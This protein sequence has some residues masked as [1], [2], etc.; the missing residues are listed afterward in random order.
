MRTVRRC[1][2]ACNDRRN[3]GLGNR[4]KWLGESG[5]G[6]Q[7]PP[8]EGCDVHVFVHLG[9]GFGAKAWRERYERGLIPGLNEPVP[10]GYHRAG[11]EGL[12]IE[13]SQDTNEGRLSAL[14]RRAVCR[15]FGFDLIHAWRNRM[16]LMTADVVWTHTEREHL[17]ALFLLQSVSPRKRPRIIAQC[18]WMFDE[19]PRLS[20]ARR[21]LYSW[22][23]SQAD[24]VTTLSPENLDVARRVLPRS[25]TELVRFGITSDSLKPARRAVCHRPVRVAALGNDMHRDW[26]TLLRAFGGIP[27]FELRIASSKVAPRL[28][29]GARNVRVEPARSREQ[30]ER[31]YEWADMVVVPLNPNL[32]A[33]G[34]SVI[35]EAT[36]SGKPLIVSDTGGLRAYFSSEEVNYV[37]VG[38]AVAMRETAWEMSQDDERRFSL[39]TLAQR[40]IVEAGLTSET[41]ALRHRRLSQELLGGVRLQNPPSFGLQ[42]SG[43]KAD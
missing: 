36:S 5:A 31:L 32:H 10:Y 25:R 43:L 40:R 26:T 21:R 4:E 12:V 20:W 37:A 6:Y 35:L 16:G 42:P 24:I 17:A 18:I 39:V 7:G 27:T 14:C 28:T 3:A 38:D 11:G 22:L 29:Q 1:A 19:W 30:V 33:S 2:K 23:L 41:Y 34:L 15:A 8:T 13:Y 9:P